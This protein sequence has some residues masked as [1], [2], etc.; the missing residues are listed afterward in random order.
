M[1][2]GLDIGTGG[3]V[4]AVL[5]GE[6]TS[7]TRIRNMFLELKPNPIIKG[8]LKKSGIPNVEMGGMI[9]ALG[10]KAMEIASAFTLT[11]RRPMAKGVINPQEVE[12][13]PILKAII[14]EALGTPAVEN[15]VCFFSVPADPV[16]AEFN[17]IYHRN[18]FE[19]MLRELGYTPKPINEGLTVIYGELLDHSLTGVGLSFGAGMCNV[20]CAMY[21]E[22][23]FSF[24]V[25]SSGDYID[26]NV[27]TAR[28][29]TPLK[30]LKI[31]ELTD[32]KNP[33]DADE[34]AVVYY[35]RHL[36]NYVLDQISVAYGHLQ[37]KPE[38]ENIPPIAIAGGT[39]MLKGFKELFNEIL[40]TKDIAFLKDAEI[41]LSEEP[42]Y[43]IA[44]GSMF[45]AISAEDE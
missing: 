25:A 11:P 14:G 15:E 29:I 41:I 24:S 20:C 1:A 7:Y 8:M 40:A 44:K 32:L 39:A 6:T 23:I 17:A 4:G 3:I 28:A 34:E 19:K 16:D 5:N 42:L 27:S 45:A 9:Y 26:Q 10:E 36:I 21:G 12:A 33:K 38:F 22:P 13:A 43:S 37:N 18:V 31:K 30:A 35:Y 2:K